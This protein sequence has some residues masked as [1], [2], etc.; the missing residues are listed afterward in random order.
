[1]RGFLLSALLAECI[2]SLNIRDNGVLDAAAAQAYGSDPDVNNE[3]V[4]YGSDPIFIS[5]PVDEVQTLP[6]FSNSIFG[7][8]YSSLAGAQSPRL[9]LEVPDPTIFKN[10]LT[11][12]SATDGESLSTVNLAGYGVPSSPEVSFDSSSYAIAAGDDVNLIEMGKDGIAALIAS[13][14]YLGGELATYT[15]S[16]SRDSTYEPVTGVA[17]YQ[18]K[19]AAACPPRIY[20]N[21]DTPYCDLGLDSINYSPNFKKYV[22]LQFTKCISF[23]YSFNT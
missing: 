23:S 15:Y 2:F 8:T 1:M 20:H 22:L 21:R 3:V 17:S 12:A 7:T 16:F 10:P 4:A 9:D 18:T 6:T 5:P 14:A 11:L 13:I 19:R